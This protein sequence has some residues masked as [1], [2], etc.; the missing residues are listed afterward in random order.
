VAL[1][2]PSKPTTPALARLKRLSM[3]DTLQPVDWGSSYR[4]AVRTGRR[5]TGDRATMALAEAAQPFGSPLHPVSRS[6]A[7]GCHD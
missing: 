3:R 1:E 2:A 6:P 4:G 5:G 7:E